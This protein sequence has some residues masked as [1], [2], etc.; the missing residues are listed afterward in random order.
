VALGVAAG[1]Y[2][3]VMALSPALQIRRM[4]LTKSA[5]DVSLG[6]FFLLLPGFMLWVAYGVAS[7]DPALFIPNVVSTLVAALLIVVALR[8]R[9]RERRADNDQA[10]G[11]AAPPAPT[12]LDR[13]P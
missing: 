11:V 8:L 1:L 13:G 6:Y 4:L 7:G 10:S 3:V 9:G 12:A 2:G 5:R